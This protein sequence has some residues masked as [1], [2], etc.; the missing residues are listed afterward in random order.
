MPPKPKR[1][2]TKSYGRQDPANTIKSVS[3][4]KALAEFADAEAKK[5]G[6]SFSAWV[7]ELLERQRGDQGDR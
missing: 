2:K 3:L 6:I 4:E 1:P 7:A 5:Q